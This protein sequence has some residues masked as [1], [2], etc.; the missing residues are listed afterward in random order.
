MKQLIAACLLVL[1]VCF[2][3]MTD[4]LAVS[5]EQ[6]QQID[7]QWQ[8]SVHALNDVNCSSCHKDKETK[9]LINQPSHESCQ[10]CHE[11]ETETFLLGKHGIRLL[12]KQSPLTPAMARIPM[13]SDAH[14]RVMNCNTCHNVHSVKTVPAAVDAC[15]TCHNDTHSLNYEKS[16]HA[17]LFRAQAASL[18]RPD[19][20]S[21]TCATCHLPRQRL[22]AEDDESLV[23]ANH[24]NTYSLLPRDRMVK[25]VCMNCHGMEY[26]YNNIFDEA[27]VEANFDRVSTQE[28]QTLE[29]IRVAGQQRGVSQSRRATNQEEVQAANESNTDTE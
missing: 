9:A 2:G 20:A 12:E 8:L 10:S 7:Q 15:L 21:V 28:L 23:F 14:S 19:R 18:P 26:S 22:D 17:Q 25:D 11:Q 27:V 4:A 6:L 29:M 1:Y 3:I 16:K 24:N 13:K 5:Q